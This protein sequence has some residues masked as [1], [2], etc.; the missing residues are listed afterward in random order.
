M[1]ILSSISRSKDN[2]TM[3]IGQLIQYNMRNIFLKKSYTECGGETIPRPFSKKK[4]EHISESIV[5]Q[6]IFI[7]CQVE[8]YGNI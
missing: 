7:V 6:F 8:G 1:H 4:V 3:K 5:L 2:H